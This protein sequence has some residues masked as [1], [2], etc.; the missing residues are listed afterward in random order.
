MNISYFLSYLSLFL[1]ICFYCSHSYASNPGTL[2]VKFGQTTEDMFKATHPY[3]ESVG[4]NKE[5]GGNIY[6]EMPNENKEVNK[7]IVH[8]D[9]KS[10]F[11]LFDQNKSLTALQLQFKNDCFS[12]LSKFMEKKYSVIVKKTSLFGSNYME[13]YHDRVAIYLITPSFFSETSLLYI[14]TDV[15]DEI[16]KNLPKATLEDERETLNA[17][18]ERSFTPNRVAR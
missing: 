11:I 18:L 5:L 1:S 7:D 15:R 10:V 17:I 8:E 16:L 14:A 12:I 6:K 3:A 13:L 4:V 9:L 2:T